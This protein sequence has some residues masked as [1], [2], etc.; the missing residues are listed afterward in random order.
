MSTRERQR[1]FVW[2]VYVREV[3]INHPEL[4]GLFDSEDRARNDVRDKKLIKS[5]ADVWY[6]RLYVESGQSEVA[7]I[8]KGGDIQ[9]TM[10]AETTREQRMELITAL[11]TKTR[12]AL[13]LL[14]D[15]DKLMRSTESL[16]EFIRNMCKTIAE[17]RIALATSKPAPRTPGWSPQ[18]VMGGRE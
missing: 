9:S 17:E 2:G 6:Q 3:G 11:E 16:R 13:E 1:E 10:T 15:T 7:T 4:F 12:T 18:P 8:C 14:A 5:F